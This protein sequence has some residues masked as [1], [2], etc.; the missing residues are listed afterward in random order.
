MIGHVGGK[1]QTI[2]KQK[3]QYFGHIA[4]REGDNLEKLIMFG[5]VE[6]KR[7][8]GRQKPRWTDGIATLTKDST[9]SCYIR[10]TKRKES[11]SPKWSQILRHE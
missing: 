5:L 1:N 4:R 11:T 7:S 6:G 10:A 2:L 3:L 9:Y 8:K